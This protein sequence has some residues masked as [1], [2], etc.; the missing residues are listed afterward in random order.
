MPD[1]LHSAAALE[2]AGDVAAAQARLEAALAVAPDDADLLTALGASLRRQGVF[3]RALPLLDRAVAAAPR[4]AAAWLER[5]YAA[6]AGGAL[7]V[8]AESYHRAGKLQPGWAAAHAGFASVARLLGYPV[9]ARQFATRAL[10]L[11][12]QDAVA[13]CTLA[14]VDLAEGDAAAAAAALDAL[15]NG[16]PLSAHNRIAAQ[17]LLGDAR[18]RLGAADAAF[19]AYAQAKT[20]FAALHAPHFAA[21]GV[22]SHHDLM[23]RLTREVAAQ[24]PSAWA[25][26]ADSSAPRGHVF[27][28]GYPR[29]GTTLVE[30]ILASAAG[31][32]AIEERPTLHAA[33]RAFLGAGG[34]ADLAALDAAGA[35]ELR[36]AYWTKVAD[37]GVDPAAGVLVDMDP[38]HS[39]RLPVIARLFGGARVVLL[40]RDPRDVVWSCFRT[41]FAANAATYEFTSVERAARHYAATM[42]FIEQ[43]LAVLPTPPLIVRYE[44]VVADFDKTTQAICAFTGIEWRPELRDFAATATRRGVGTASV[45]QVR[46]G[47]YDG[48][49]QWRPYAAQLAEAMPILQPW[50]D[51]FGYR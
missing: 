37:C 36:A 43:C 4:H 40:R 5:G 32:E 18:A 29:S 19:D 42:T 34:M 28:L 45:T 33:D 12:A 48:S 24:P 49:G 23:L 14:A 46:R 13:V 10:G 44:D 35:A 20:G 1:V 27:L 9:A 39:V 11:D 41:S 17:M 50:I 47:L 38:L 2:A 31:V 21:P 51:R 6:E 25:S 16:A 15:L 26:I 3:S 22:E 30:N 8:A 7:E